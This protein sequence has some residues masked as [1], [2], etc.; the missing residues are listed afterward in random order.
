MSKSRDSENESACYINIAEDG[1][2]EAGM[3]LKN[4]DVLT[5]VLHAGVNRAEATLPSGNHFPAH[6]LVL[7]REGKNI[8]RESSYFGSDVVEVFDS[9]I[10]R[11]QKYWL[12]GWRIYRKKS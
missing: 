5:V 4:D 12:G 9:S 10:Q 7:V 11:G 1:S 3:I 8:V 6:K 2:A